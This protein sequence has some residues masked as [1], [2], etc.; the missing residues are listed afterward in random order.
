MGK[1]NN[2]KSETPK[3]KQT[4]HLQTQQTNDQIIHVINFLLSVNV[5]GFVFFF[6]P[7]FKSGHGG[8][9]F[10]NWLSLEMSKQTWP[11]LTRGW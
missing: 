5:V 9:E 6:F 7:Q 2:W 10:S 11:S 4:P 8:R 3:N 1:K